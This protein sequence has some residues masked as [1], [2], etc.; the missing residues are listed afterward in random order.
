MK[1]FTWGICDGT[2]EGGETWLLCPSNFVE[3]FNWGVP[4]D[5]GFSGVGVS[6]VDAGV[7]GEPEIFCEA[8]FGGSCCWDCIWGVAGN[9]WLT[10]GMVF[11]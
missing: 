11:C 4:L 8:G 1:L 2:G 9:V 10:G 6:G 7:V 3:D 5:C